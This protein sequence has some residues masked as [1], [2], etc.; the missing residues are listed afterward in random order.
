MLSEFERLRRLEAEAQRRAE[1]EARDNLNRWNGSKALILAYA[2]AKLGLP[3]SEAEAQLLADNAASLELDLNFT[4]ESIE[5]ER[6]LALV[7]WNSNAS[8]QAA[9]ASTSAGGGGSAS[10]PD[11]AASSSGGATGT[12]LGAAARPLPSLPPRRPDHIVSASSLSQPGEVD[13]LEAEAAGLMALITDILRASAT[14]LSLPDLSAAIHAR[15]GKRW[16][17]A[18]EGAHG[19][20][21]S[22]IRKN[23][24]PGYHI[25]TQNRFLS[26]PG[27]PLP[28]PPETAAAV[29]PATDAMVAQPPMQMMQPVMTASQQ[30]QQPMMMGAYE[31]QQYQAMM[32]Q[33]QQQ[34]YA[35]TAYGT[36]GAGANWQYAFGGGWP[37]QQAAY[38]GAYGGTFGV[39]PQ[40]QQQQ[41]AADFNPFEDTFSSTATSTVTSSSTSRDAIVPKRGWELST[42]TSMGFDS[43]RG[44]AGSELSQTRGHATSIG[45][46]E[47]FSVTDA[48]RRR[49]TKTR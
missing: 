14:G 49:T 19:T 36:A 38:D 28:P 9:A 32:A 21:L 40:Q 16:G 3:I 43:S 18:Y 15:T 26:L 11:S 1:Q 34:Q 47:A 33:Q 7:A 13:Q 35:A 45:G 44:R 12:S 2:R 22:F 10:T 27:Q 4:A 30:L 25:I 24:T 37:Q 41:P 6:A 29:V 42:V 5:R 31:Q 20:L 8:Q 48:G 17:S 23:G 39:M 46:V